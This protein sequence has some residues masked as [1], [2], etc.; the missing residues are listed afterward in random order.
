[1]ANK[2]IS[3]QNSIF[4]GNQNKYFIVNNYLL[5]NKLKSL[6]SDKNIILS[7][8]HT[9]VVS[10]VLIFTTYAF[11]RTAKLIRYRKNTRK[12]KSLKRIKS[13]SKMSSLLLKNNSAKIIFKIMLLNLLINRSQVAKLYLSYKRFVSVLFSRGLNLFLD[14][15]KVTD[16][17]SRKLISVSGYLIILGRIF[18]VLNK[19]KHN[20]FVFF[21]TVVFDNLVKNISSDILGVKMVINGKLLGKTRS[22]TIK[23]EKGSLKINSL[24]SNISFSKCHVYTLYGA[25][26]FKLWINYK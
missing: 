19:K 22:S 25:F 17:L 16:L 10:N 3:K 18:K 5:Q 13:L 24:N 4:V 23:I 6:Y 15:L 9:A 8:S 2:I 26:G 1:M 21:L 11:Y 14:F 12:K 7:E 20:R